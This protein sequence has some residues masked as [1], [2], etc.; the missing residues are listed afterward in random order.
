MLVIF[1]TVIELSV[2]EFEF[3]LPLLDVFIYLLTNILLGGLFIKLIFK[4]VLRKKQINIRK[5]YS[6]I[7]VA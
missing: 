7:N 2:A 1:T 3:K 6:K 4:G 5:K